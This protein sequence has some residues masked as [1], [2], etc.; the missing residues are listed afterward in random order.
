M[1]LTAGRY[2]I[3]SLGN[4]LPVGRSQHEDLS[5][6][7]KR[8]ITL[9]QGVQPSVW[10]IQRAGSGN[11]II[12]VNGDPTATFDNLLWAILHQEPRPS[13]WKITIR[14]QAGPDTF[15]IEL[16]DGSG[17][18]W[19]VPDDKPETQLAVRHLI[20]GPSDPPFFPPNQLFVIRP[21]LD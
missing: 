18:G 5:L 20:I 6:N 7:P 19:V 15:T 2:I 1:S 9:P 4:K 11:F 17:Q 13:E 16:A 12:R 21:L 14:P 3:T 10:E 8:V